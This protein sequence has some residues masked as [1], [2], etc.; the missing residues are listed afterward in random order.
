MNLG[1]LC[2]IF[3]IVEIV[4]NKIK[5]IEFGEFRNPRRNELFVPDDWG[6]EQIMGILFGDGYDENKFSIKENSEDSFNLFE[7]GSDINIGKNE[8]IIDMN[9]PDDVFNLLEI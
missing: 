9:F 1:F 5:S 2:Q 6:T 3:M 7:V 8:N 4:D